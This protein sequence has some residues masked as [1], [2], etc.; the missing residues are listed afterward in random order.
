MDNAE[1]RR[2]KAD[3]VAAYNDAA[4]R[5]PTAT[6]PSQLGSTTRTPGVYNT[7][8]GVFQLTGTLILDAE[9]DPDAVFILQA[10]SLVT[11]NVSNIDLVGGAQAN[12]V[13]W[14]LDDSATLGT[15]ST[16][17]GN[18]LARSSVAVT[19]GVALYGRAIA[20][21]G[22][23]TLDG[24]SHLP[25]TRVT[26]P[27]EPPTITTVTSSSNPS[28]R[29]EPV[30]FTATVHGPTDSVVPAGQVLFKDGD[31]VIGSAYNSSA[32]PATITTSDL[33]RGA[34]DITAVYLNGGTA[35]NEAWTYF[36]PSTSEVLT[37][38]VLNRRS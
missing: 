12:N 23:V 37:Q 34:H 3:A 24:T 4:R 10:A 32:A 28:R 17:R 27:D 30:T 38:V 11:A 15:Y 36:A 6:I 31:T 35:V 22:M 2:E 20:L 26:P 13:I 16:F 33:T 1:A 25:A 14:Q 7:A 8:G 21:N 29:G 18:I 5:T 19:T 9:G